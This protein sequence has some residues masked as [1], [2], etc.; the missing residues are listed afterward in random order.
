[1]PEYQTA[2]D[3]GVTLLRGVYGDIDLTSTL[4]AVGTWG[5]LYFF[6]WLLVSR[7]LLLNVIVAILMG[8]PTGMASDLE[9]ETKLFEALIICPLSTRACALE[10]L[11]C[12]PRTRPMIPKP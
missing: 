8:R 11:G 6:F 10:W 4:S 9:S 5:F 2:V 3:T 7:T 12:A 1:M